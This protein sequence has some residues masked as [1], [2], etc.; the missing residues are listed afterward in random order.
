[1]VLGSTHIV[2]QL[3]FSTL[4][5]ILTFVLLN[6]GVVLSFLGPTW[7]FFGPRCFSKS[8]LEYKHKGEKILFSVLPSFIT[9]VFDL[10][11]ASQGKVQKLFW[12]LLM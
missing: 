2:Q 8:I 4:P 11:F 7:L 1:M 9:F 12:G 10:Y 3:L 6:L 5:S